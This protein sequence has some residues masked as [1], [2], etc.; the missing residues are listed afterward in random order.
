VVRPL[1]ELIR[2]LPLIPLPGT[3]MQRQQPIDV[4]DLAR[5]VSLSVT[6]DALLNTEISVG[7]P[8]YLTLRNLVDL[9]QGELGVAKPKVLLPPGWISAL[10]PIVPGG[11]RELFAGPRLALFQQM[12]AASPGIVQQ[13]FG[14]QPVSV[15]SRLPQ[16]LG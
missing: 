1:A 8:A 12:S 6:D 11:A 5:C 9:I 14:F 16:Y 13:Q 10:A 15:V 2:A 3:G 4:E 7:G